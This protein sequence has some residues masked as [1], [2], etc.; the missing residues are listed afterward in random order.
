MAIDFRAGI[1]RILSADRSTAGSGFVAA[2]RSDTVL[3]VT[4]S[5]VVQREASQRLGDGRPETV[6]VAFHAN[7]EVA[8]AVVKSEWWRP[9]DKEDVALLAL[10]GPL[11]AEVRPLPLGSDGGIKGHDF[12]S[13]GY[14]L[15][16]QFDSGLEAI[17]KIL[18][19][20]SYQGHAVLQLSSNQVDHGMSG[21]PLWDVKRQR[22]VGM[23]NSFWG[24][25]H[26]RDADLAFAT[27]SSTLQATC[28]NLQPSDICPYRGLSAFTEEEALFFSGRLTLTEV[29]R[30]KLRQN[31]QFLAI[32][33][34]SGSGKSSLVQAG[35]LPRLRRGELPGFDD[36]RLAVFRP[37]NEPHAN[38]LRALR[39]TGI[40]S[41]GHR[42]PFAIIGQHLNRE[43]ER[44][45]VVLGEQFEEVFALAHRDERDKFLAGLADLVN[46]SRLFTLIIT[47]RADFYDP[48]QRSTLGPYLDTGQ[49]NVRSTMSRA[50]LVEAITAPASLVGFSVEAGIGDLMLG[51]LGRTQNPLP[52]MESALT[53]L[54][55]HRQDGEL[56]LDYYR[57]MGGATGAISQWAGK[58]IQALTEEEKRE[59]RRILTRLVH[60]AT[61]DTPDTCQPLA[62]SELVPEHA[63]SPAGRVLKAL[64]D[65]RIVVTDTVDGQG[66][67]EI[68]HE[69]LLCEWP[70][71]TKWVQED[72]DF[73]KWLQR[74]NTKRG[75]WEGTKH[76]EGTL[77]SGTPMAEAQ[78]WARIRAADL[79]DPE[80]TFIAESAKV[81]RRTKV[82]QN[83][84]RGVASAVAFAAVV[85]IGLFRVSRTDWYQIRTILAD[86]AV[87]PAHLSDFD[88]QQWAVALAMVGKDDDALRIAK[89]LGSQQNRDETLGTIASIFARQKKADKAI[90]V[91]PMIVDH[92]WRQ[93]ATRVVAEGLA[94]SGLTDKAVQTA[95]LLDKD[96]QADAFTRMANL[97]LQTRAP[98]GEKFIEEAGITAGKLRP[99]ERSNLLGE[100]ARVLDHFE[101]TSQAA[102]LWKQARAAA[103]QVPLTMELTDQRRRWFQRN[104]T[105]LNLAERLGD[106]GRTADAEALARAI[107]DPAYQHEAFRTIALD[108]AKR[109]KSEEAKTI[110]RDSGLIPGNDLDFLLPFD[111]SF[112]RAFALA[113]AGHVGEAMTVIRGL[114]DQSLWLPELTELAEELTLLG[115]KSGA[116]AVLEEA[117]ALGVLSAA[118]AADG[119]LESVASTMALAGDT[120]GAISVIAHLRDL[121]Y[122]PSALNHI[123]K[124]LADSGH[125]AQAKLFCEDAIDA[126]EPTSS[127]SIVEIVDSLAILAEAGEIKEAL[128]IARRTIDPKNTDQDRS[129]RVQALAGIAEAVGHQRGGHSRAMAIMQEASMTLGDTYIPLVERYSIQ[130]SMGETYARL[131]EFRLARLACD[132]YETGAKISVYSLILTEYA[133]ARDPLLVNYPLMSYP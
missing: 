130:R 54:W 22:V 1:V 115:D 121:G 8:S 96:H 15:S 127:S 67:A 119:P 87:D 83:V 85:S 29:L 106:V 123:A 111:N 128:D 44:R 61:G 30:D 16:A 11:P 60:Y 53:E 116:A 70:Q 98:G 80:R 48:L 104:G 18:G 68:V 36:L 38:L 39:K 20:I 129:D 5:H 35:L 33:G 84:L 14:R 50:E 86:P 2:S 92:L 40:S 77:L 66:T 21:A 3:I 4:C 51:D 42:D 62:L 124:S 90:N 23:V 12:E 75:E 31:P 27:P 95:H 82:S 114:K 81:S 99:V 105:L 52:L 132:G 89:G 43:R 109:G 100:L 24:T 73:H 108:L 69:S 45:I 56:K 64:A 49:V 7:G 26:H 47:V 117:Y 113:F 103:D 97:A 88:V 17:G 93:L 120:R 78:H 63:D 122:R 102:I 41:E 94:E 13:R 71:L 79:T 46:S 126:A 76:A 131:G 101:R 125:S 37:L 28:P 9:A 10:E 110:I 34:P 32:V 55:K 118:D 57:A 19:T 6:T 74:L 58:T 107:N 72:R 59:A 91:L 65:A 112:D 25:E 133:H